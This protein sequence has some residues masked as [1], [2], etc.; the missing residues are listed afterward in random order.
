MPMYLTR[1]PQSHAVD[2]E[3]N[4]VIDTAPQKNMV[5][6]GLD[7][8]HIDRY[9]ELTRQHSELE[10][11]LFAIITDQV[12]MSSGRGGYYN[13]IQNTL[14][15]IDR[16]GNRAMSSNSEL[17]GLTFMTRPKLNLPSGN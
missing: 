3:G 14:R 1:V 8:A 2:E 13:Q 16:F 11:I 7:Q 15:N 9:L 6:A 10:R 12:N 4:P 5:L 17:S